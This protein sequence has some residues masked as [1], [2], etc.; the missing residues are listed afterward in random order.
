[1]NL[2]LRF[3]RICTAS[4]RL[5]KHTHAQAAVDSMFVVANEGSENSAQR[6]RSRMAFLARTRDHDTQ[7]RLHVGIELSMATHA[8]RFWGRE[9]RS[10][11]FVSESGK[12]SLG[13]RKRKKHGGSGCWAK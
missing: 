1:M 3:F 4:P 12:F 5:K 6:G 11:M 7:T 8:T 13:T 9:D 2:D 10:G